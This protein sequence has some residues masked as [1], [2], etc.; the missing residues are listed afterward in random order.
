LKSV[1]LSEHSRKFTISS[2]A[3]SVLPISNDNFATTP[4][5]QNCDISAMVNSKKTSAINKNGDVTPTNARTVIYLFIYLF[6]SS[7]EVISN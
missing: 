7:T 1:T 5:Q 2:G 6:V 4:C 3:N